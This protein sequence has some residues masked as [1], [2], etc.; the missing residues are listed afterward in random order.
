MSKKKARGAAGDASGTSV[1][2]VVHSHFVDND[3]DHEVDDTHGV[4]ASLAGARRAA[5]ALME[6]LVLAGKEEDGSGSHDDFVPGD[7]PKK[8]K[9]KRRKTKDKLPRGWTEKDANHFEC[10]GVELDGYSGVWITEE[11]LRP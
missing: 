10:E 6:P 3:H 9:T 5:V 1:V 8:G 4:F 11:K 7:S 2:Y